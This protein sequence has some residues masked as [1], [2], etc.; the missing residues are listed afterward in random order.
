MK[1]HYYRLILSIFLV[2]NV[3][4]GF[5]QTTNNTKIYIE[6]LWHFKTSDYIHYS[7]A[8][9]I[10]KGNMEL[11]GN[12]ENVSA[13]A[14][15][16]NQQSTGLLIF[17]GVST[18]SVVGNNDFINVDLKNNINISG[19]MNVSGTVSLGSSEI[20]GG[21]NFTLLAGA[22]AATSHTNGLNGNLFNTGSLS[23]SDAANYKYF[24]EALQE[25]G[26]FLPAKINNLVIDKALNNLT[27]TKTGLTEID[28][29][30]HVVSGSFIINSEAAIT[31]TGNTTIE[32]PSGL[33]LESDDNGTASFIDNGTINGSGSASVKNYL[34]YMATGD[35]GR[36][37]SVPTNNAHTDDLENPADG[38]FIFNP[39]IADWEQINNTPLLVMNGYVTKYPIA[40]TL[41]YTGNL[42]TG[43]I[44]RSDLIRHN[45]SGVNNFGWNLAGN[46]YPSSLDWSNVAITSNN[47]N[48]SIH[49]RK[50]DGSI[51]AFV[52]GVGTP[53]GTTGIIPPMQAFWVQVALGQNNATLSFDNNARVHTQ[54]PLYKKTTPPIIRL[55]ANNSLATNE[56]VI[57]F[58]DMAT[59]MFDKQYDA[60]N[61]NTQNISQPD[62]YSFSNNGFELSVNA[63]PFNNNHII[64]PL[65][66]KTN[67][68]GTHTIEA[69]DFDLI[70]PA[71]N[72][73]LEDKKLN[74]MHDI[75]NQNT[76]T[77]NYVGTDTVNRFD[78]HFNAVT[79]NSEQ[80]IYIS[81]D[82]Y[83]HIHSSENILFITFSDIN[84]S[85]YKLVVYDITGRQVYIESL[86]ST[87][88]IHKVPLNIVTGIYFV[89]LFNEKHYTKSKIF[90]Q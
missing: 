46:P 21:G 44:Q 48:A 43:T 9:I 2:F 18:Q 73:F 41:T 76:Y 59:Q 36:Y 25:T 32:T 5:S 68:Y 84:E 80:D 1:K 40:K 79:I 56:T 53:Q 7:N 29:V 6:D 88:K 71:V 55:R 45:M 65:G 86:N 70:D 83:A 15:V 58:N 85:H 14:E 47:L 35:K 81:K 22:T 90:I 49:F 16:F 87:S 69:F 20:I 10:L 30:L 57:V 39:S 62:F 34:K 64:V 12:W 89:H 77:F 17:E 61:I 23:L 74:V 26:T 19:D 28:G 8:E 78:L 63:I 82:F 3:F 54:L 51:A 50:A 31:V 67:A 37:L 27:L 75:R 24:G 72:I 52:D 11:T 13:S 38:I 33:V 66:Y 42:N 60:M 4:V